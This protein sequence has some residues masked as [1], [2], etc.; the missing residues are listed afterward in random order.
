MRHVLLSLVIFLSLF[1]LKIA[2]EAMADPAQVK[3][4]QI[5]KEARISL[6]TISPGNQLYTR[7]GHSAIRI[8]D[9]QQELDI[10]YNYGTFDF[11][12]PGFYT[13]FL[14]GKLL[15]FLS[16]YSFDRMVRT[17]EYFNQSVYEQELNLTFEQKIAV[18][19]FLNWNYLPDNRYYLYDFFYDNCSSRIRD[20][21]QDV[22]KENLDFHEY[23][24][25]LFI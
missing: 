7:F 16:V 11:D 17:Y 12:T 10:V 1:H 4:P 24:L 9:P 5:S 13:K 3:F 15:Y 8:N 14:R 25:I 2:G 6:I 21:F 23:I 18:Y 19:N 22:V 20:V